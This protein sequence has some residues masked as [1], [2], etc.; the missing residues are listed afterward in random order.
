MKLV[1]RTF[2]I[3]IGC[4]GLC[5][6]VFAQDRNPTSPVAIA[7]GSRVAIIGDS[8]TEQ[9]QYSKFIEAYL[10]ACSGISDV[11]TCQFGWGGERAD[12]FAARLE[13]DLSVF[14][15]TVAT[16]CYGMND[17]GYQAYKDE[18]GKSYEGNMRNVLT[19]LE[20][21]GV[22]SIVVGSPGAV[23][24][25]FFRPGQS[26]GDRPAHVVY[27]DNLAHLRDIDRTLAS[28]VKQR[29]ADVHATMFDAMTKAQEALGKQ[30][31]VC[32]RDGFHP[33]G[34]G[35][36]L[37]AYAFLKS[38]DLK[39]DIGEIV[40]DLNGK[41]T[42]SEGH[43]IKGGSAGNIEIES[44]RWPFCFQG[45]ET[46]S[47]GTR[48][49]VRFTNFNEDLNRLIVKVKG[50]STNNARVK[51]GEQEKQFTRAQ[52]EQGINLMKE[53]DATPFDASFQALLEAIATKQN[54]ETN[55]IKGSIT[56][57]RNMPPEL[58][59]DVEMKKAVGMMRDRFA[60]RHKE[61]DATVHAVLKPITYK[62]I[63]SP[64]E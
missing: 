6:P 14:N 17:G 43:S 42:A 21:A 44:S 63:V 40:I 59:N 36:L 15:P 1:R 10:L 18:I 34:N 48:S 61:L 4:I 64:A 16:L 13:N 58:A 2:I 45:D 62:L 50:L 55:M 57:L 24:A 26:M 33:G 52:L 53:F 11:H 29:F 31:D 5:V 47:S 56:H 20:K 39:G 19:K 60:S 46:S 23:D 12:G 8:I 25:Y 41:S 51:W 28:E 38:L 37:M 27:N 54:F 35:H 49:I 9:K 32:G 30:Y 22:K 3:A 7:T